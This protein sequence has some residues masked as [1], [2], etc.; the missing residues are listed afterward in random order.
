VDSF[1]AFPENREDGLRDWHEARIRER[2]AMPRFDYRDGWAAALAV[3]GHIA[4]GFLFAHWLQVRDAVVAAERIT[5]VEFIDESP[6]AASAAAPVPPETHAAPAPIAEARLPA[7]PPLRPRRRQAQ[8]LQA[9]EPAPSSA[10][11]L[12]PDGSLRLPE[13]FIEGIDDPLD[14]DR[15]FSYQ[16]RGLAE[17]Q[18]LMADRP[19]PLQ[20]EPTRFDEDWLPTEDMLSEILNK[21][22]EATTKQVEIPL[23]GG[24]SKLVCQISLLAMGGGC[25]PIRLSSLQPFQGDDPD[26]LNPSEQAQCD[27]W[28]NKIVSATTQETWRQTRDL[29]EAQCR[30]PKEANEKGP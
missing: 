1:E 12:N 28:W 3:A 30:K 8:A 22:V 14:P 7:P 5:V 4:L 10:P 6:P 18:R 17:G 11:L 23:P 25:V 16:V 29:Y 19:S 13:G 26:T 2:A 20:Y 15:E 24:R 27:A 9:V 21:A